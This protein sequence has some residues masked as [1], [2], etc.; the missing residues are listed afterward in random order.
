MTLKD[1]IQVFSEFNELGIEM[2]IIQ[3]DGADSISAESDLHTPLSEIPLLTSISMGSNVCHAYYEDG[4]L[5]VE[6][7]SEKK[8][9]KMKS[10]RVKPKNKDEL[11]RIIDKTI[12]KEG[13]ECSLN[14]IDTSLI[15][16]MS[17]LFEN[18]DFNGDISKWDVSN[19]T[20]MF[21]MFSGAKS[22]NQPLNDWDVSNVEDMNRMFSN[23]KSFNQPLD[24]WNTSKVKDMSGMFENAKSFNQ[25]IGNWDVS[26]VEDMSWL[27]S[28][29]TSF[30]Q[31]LNNWNVS[32]VMF[33]CGMFDNA[34][35]FN[36]PLNSW[37]VSNV[38][39]MSWMFFNAQS[40]DQDLSNWDTSSV[41]DMNEM[42]S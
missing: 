1:F 18:S 35:S 5:F 26:H 8:G 3:Y 28:D 9:T 7:E 6:L 23:A 21:R 29:A 14:F 25:P 12:S 32:N 10:T 17:S 4:C 40:F 33:M 30:N 11:I 27:F 2:C 20:D 41:Q 15:K 19:V 13:N 31:P 34:E 39:D 38:D 22:F 24:K 42:F 37:N 36:Q 16:N